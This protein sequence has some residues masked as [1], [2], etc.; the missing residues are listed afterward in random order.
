MSAKIEEL[1]ERNERVAQMKEDSN[2][3]VQDNNF[4]ELSLKFELIF[5]QEDRRSREV[6]AVLNLFNVPYTPVGCELKPEKQRDQLLEAK[7]VPARLGNSD[8][9]RHRVSG[10]PRQGNL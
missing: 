9:R 5:P 7:G 8:R 3:L 4:Y 1:K 6:E 2:Q 10:A